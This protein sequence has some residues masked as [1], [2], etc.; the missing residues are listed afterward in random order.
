MNVAVKMTTTL[1]LDRGRDPTS[2]DK[3][4]ILATWR[5]INFKQNKDLRTSKTNTNIVQINLRHSQAA[6]VE[7]LKRIQRTKEL[8]L[9]TEPWVRG[10]L[11][12]G[13]DQL[14]TFSKGKKPRA[15]IAA[16]KGLKAMIID[17][18]SEEDFVCCSVHTDE[19]LVYVISAYWDIN[20]GKPLLERLERI[21]TA[22]ESKNIP[23]ILGM[24]S[25]AHSPLWGCMESNQRGKLLED[26]IQTNDLFVENVG[27]EVTFETSRASS[28]IDIT[29][30]NLKG[31]KLVRGWRVDKTISM[32]DHKYL[33]YGLKIGNTFSYTYRRR[34]DKVDWSDF[35]TNLDSQETPE[36][37]FGIKGIETSTKWL[38]DQI[39]SYLR[40]E[41]PKLLVK[42]R[43][44]NWWNHECETQ[45]RIV[46]RLLRKKDK[47]T[48]DLVE[49]KLA[50]KLY[51]KAIYKAKEHGWGK[52]VDGLESTRDVGRLAKALRNPLKREIGALC[53]EGP[54]KTLNKLMETHFPDCRPT[55]LPPGGLGFQKVKLLAEQNCVCTEAEVRKALNSFGD[56]KAIGADG[57]PPKALKELPDKYYS[58][59]ANL[60]NR[61][62]E[63]GYTPIVWREMKVIYIPKPGKPDYSI[64]KAYRPITLSSYLLKGM[65]KVIKDKILPII[66]PKMT[67]QFAFLKGKSTDTALSKVV[68]ELEK[69]YLNKGVSA[70]VL[71]D[72]EGAFDRVPFTQIRKAMKRFK[73]PPDIIEWYDQLVRNRIIFSELHGSKIWRVPGMGTPQGGVLSPL[74]WNLVMQSILDDFESGPVKITG[75]ADDQCITAGGIDPKSVTGNLQ[76]AVDRIMVW[77]KRVGL[78]FN[79]GKTQYIMLSRRKNIH[80]NSIYVKGTEIKAVSKVNYLGVIIDQNLTWAANITNRSKKALKAAHSLKGLSNKNWG[81]DLGKCR[82]LIKSIISPI[83]TYGAIVW[84]DPGR[85]IDFNRVARPLLMS[86]GQFFRTTPT[87]ALWVLLDIAPFDILARV[88]A[89]KARYQTSSAIRTIWDGLG[90][91]GMGHQRKLDKILGNKSMDEVSI[92][93]KELWKDR[94]C[95]A[96]GLRQAKFYIN[97]TGTDWYS[98]IKN[99]TKHDIRILVGFITGHFKFRKHL[100]KLGLV[101]ESTCR[102]CGEADEDSHHLIWNC[103]TFEQ[104]RVLD[105]NLGADRYEWFVELSLHIGS[106][107]NQ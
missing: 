36:V 54:D 4:A 93:G 96:T 85:N 26:F 5:L 105:T 84:A 100:G 40:R 33:T 12:K 55:R 9:I 82:W 101:E 72:I 95:N 83:V 99:R 76:K 42:E 87:E 28:I 73:I 66:E 86:C 48:S 13:L 88:L 71:L 16:P 27:K 53:Q 60:Y 98:I 51:K 80:R 32:S 43:R 21:M 3:E 94:W 50:N 97:E 74:I 69:N 64:P 81:L 75:F 35:K 25:N 77:G 7:L 107:M 91:P 39:W 57:I 89:G 92:W 1:S 79:P 10:E 59:I 17:D 44:N 104:R 19:G 62:I 52:F 23:L 29:L 22:A 103:P 30:T 90:N 15:A 45:R 46:R 78:T 18:L 58:Y 47:S 65:E 8:A 102:F 70:A 34:F 106:L 14:K 38:H 63:V 6:S 20:L 11:V 68:D 67:N 31:S 61:C 24:D 49:L 37:N 56:R 41:C 2:V